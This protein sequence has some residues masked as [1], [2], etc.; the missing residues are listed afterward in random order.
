MHDRA[1]VGC[2]QAWRACTLE[3]LS[4]GA[5]LELAKPAYVE[6]AVSDGRV[7]MSTLRY[8]AVFFDLDDTL[9]DHQA[10]RLWNTDIVGAAA[11]GM[12]AVWS[13]FQSHSSALGVSAIGQK[14]S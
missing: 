11:S 8:R 14:R 3:K 13:P 9:F 4:K 1:L 2:L 12:S 10:H 6:V 7:A 5:A